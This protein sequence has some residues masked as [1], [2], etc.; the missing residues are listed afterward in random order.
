MVPMGMVDL[1]RIGV[2]RDVDLILIA[3]STIAIAERGCP[4]K[5]IF[6]LRFLLFIV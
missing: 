4:T 6:V 5:I 3:E 2:D 1:P